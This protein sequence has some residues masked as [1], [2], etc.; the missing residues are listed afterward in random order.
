[1]PTSLRRR[2]GPAVAIAALLAFGAAAPAAA[3]SDV[4]HSE[5]AD[6][7]VL[8]APPA[9]VVLTFHAPVRVTTL[10]LLDGAG[11]ERPVRREGERGAAVG[12]V[13]AAVQGAL[14]PGDYRIEWRGVSPDGHAGGGAVRFRVEPAR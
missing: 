10:R 13:R 2:G 6:G 7:A 3:H 8:R 11:R 9:T 14:P 1:M 4:H 12:E 5:P